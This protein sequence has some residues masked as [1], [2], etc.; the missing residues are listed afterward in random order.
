MLEVIQHFKDVPC[1]QRCP[2]YL[3]QSFISAACNGSRIAPKIKDSFLLPF[4]INRQR[5]DANIIPRLI[6]GL[7]N[8]IS[9]CFLQNAIM[10]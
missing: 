5:V 1:F 4:Y 8:L 10:N 7:C 6:D 3:A 9:P 2:K